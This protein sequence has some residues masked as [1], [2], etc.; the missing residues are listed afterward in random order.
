MHKEQESASIQDLAQFFAGDGD[1]ADGQLPPAADGD[2]DGVPVDDPA[3]TADE[4]SAEPL[5]QPPTPRAG[6]THWLGIALATAGLA[7]AALPPLSSAAAA[8]TAAGFTPGT[9]ALIG[10]LLVAIAASRGSIAA[11]AAHGA[12][13]QAQQV[14]DQAENRDVLGWLAEHHE[15]TGGTATGDLG[16]FH[17]GLQRLDE[18]VGNLTKAT[19]MYGKPLMDLA[20]QSADAAAALGQ[21]RTEVDGLLEALKLGFQRLEESVASATGGGGEKVAEELRRLGEKLVR[22]EGVD[23][24]ITRLQGQ[25][26][27]GLSRFDD[28]EI[29]RSLAK[30]AETTA[31]GF[32]RVAKG[33]GTE[34]AT[35][36]LEQGLDRT[37]QHLQK[38]LDD[39][40]KGQM[41]ALENSMRELQRETAGIATAVA[42]IQHAIKSGGLRSAAPVAAPAA[43]APA[44]PVATP[45]PSTPAPAAAS[46]AQTGV[47][48]NATGE[49][50]TGARNVL[51]AIAKL[52]QMKN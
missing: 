29:R 23:A 48:Q 8:C 9:F 19:K 39:L 14:A 24:S 51:G 38:G 17:T 26:Q 6:I 5:P 36:R 20:T 34:A 2:A 46:D 25:L 4:A 41:T 33:E 16:E 7:L 49:R 11:T 21:M 10:L 52:K 27:A 22:V 1:A 18:K 12:W 31:K 32:E 13:L 50:K 42:G 45:A 15:R 37:A 40:Q 44:A 43:P 3:A 47:A 28:A 35:K 30:L